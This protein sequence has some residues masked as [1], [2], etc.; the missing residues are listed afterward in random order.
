MQEGRVREGHELLERLHT[1]LPATPS[2]SR[3]ASLAILRAHQVINAETWDDPSLSW[4]IDLSDATVVPRAIDAFTHAYAGARHG[5]A[6]AARRG[7]A[8]IHALGESKPGGYGALPEVPRI[9]AGIL[10]A[11]VLQAGGDQAQAIAMLD[12]LGKVVGTLPVDFGPPDLVKPVHELL[13]EWLMQAHRPKE[14]EQAFVR[15]LELAPGRLRSL[16][17]LVR[18]AD[19]SNDPEV[20]DGARRTL[21]ALRAVA[22]PGVVALQ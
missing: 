2:A 3:R 8:A 4:P 7:I 1:Q 15:A 19:A 18:A 22:D 12:S 5:D 16:Q 13:G 17:G 14:A 21:A 10:E 6:A 9:L 20:A 11:G